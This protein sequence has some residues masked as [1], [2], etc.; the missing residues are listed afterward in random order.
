MALLD[1]FFLSLLSVVLS[2]T[3][4]YGTLVSILCVDSTGHHTATDP[5]NGPVGLPDCI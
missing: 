3:V 4:C 2:L 1:S 5:D